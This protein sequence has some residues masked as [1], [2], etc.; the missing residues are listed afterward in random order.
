MTKKITKISDE[1][2]EIEE[3]P[4]KYILTKQVI[5]ERLAHFETV[6]DEYKDLLKRFD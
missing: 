2:L 4:E 1:E 6:V 3:E 5:Q